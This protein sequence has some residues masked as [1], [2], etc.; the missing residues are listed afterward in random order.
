MEETS[1]RKTLHHPSHSW[2]LNSY[3]HSTH[4]VDVAKK[5][6]N[7]TKTSTTMT[8][9]PSSVKHPPSDLIV[10]WQK[11]QERTLRTGVFRISFRNTLSTNSTIWDVNRVDNKMTY[12]D[13]RAANPD[14]FVRHSCAWPRCWAQRRSPVGTWVA[15]AP[16]RSVKSSWRTAMPKRKEKDEWHR[17]SFERESLD[18]ITS[19]TGWQS[20]QS[21]AFCPPHSRW[22]KYYWFL[23]V[24]NTFV[25]RPFQWSP[26][27]DYSP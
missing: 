1:C 7:T 25:R 21:R 18:C 8:L 6:E 22:D 26:S 19:A 14:P 4:R 10:I 27:K 5:T 3:P 2:L 24:E 9:H 11:Q 23:T 12:R 13:D 15:S 20:S 16:I 17:A